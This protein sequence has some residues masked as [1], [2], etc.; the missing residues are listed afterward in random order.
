MGHL[1]NDVHPVTKVPYDKDGF[2]IFESKHT[3][4]LDK[5]DFK[6]VETSILTN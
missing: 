2:P 4:T 3:L 6:K 5:A 1:K